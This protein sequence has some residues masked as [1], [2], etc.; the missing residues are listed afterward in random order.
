MQ[1]L[2]PVI[3][4]VMNVVSKSKSVS[5]QVVPKL[6]EG[7]DLFTGVSK[8]RIIANKELGLKKYDVAMSLIDTIPAVL[9]TVNKFMELQES[10]HRLEEARINERIQYKAS[11]T[12]KYL[13]EQETKRKELD[14]EETIIQVQDKRDDRDFKKFVLSEFK[15]NLSFYPEDSE[16]GMKARFEYMSLLSRSL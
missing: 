3:P 7:L 13:S 9:G 1:S 16:L 15:N 14:L 5:N 2:V 10:S 6:K 11:E 12:T 4:S 8:E